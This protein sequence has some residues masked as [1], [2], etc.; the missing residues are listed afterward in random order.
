MNNLW[1]LIFV[2]HLVDLTALMLLIK[3]SCLLRLENVGVDGTLSQIFL[4]KDYKN[5]NVVGGQDCRNVVICVGYEPASNQLAFVYV[6]SHY[7]P[8][9]VSSLWFLYDI[10]SL[11]LISGHFLNS[12]SLSSFCIPVN[13]RYSVVFEVLI[14]I[15]IFR[16][17]FCPVSLLHCIITFC[18]MVANE[19]LEA[20][21]TWEIAWTR[22]EVVMVGIQEMIE[23]TDERADLEGHTVDPGHALDLVQEQG[24]LQECIHTWEHTQGQGQELYRGHVHY[25]HFRIHLHQMLHGHLKEVQ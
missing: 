1:Y 15:L 18:L 23:V 2:K 5:I 17:S 7:Y 16:I 3:M 21:Q 14:K 6:M 24:H 12:Q 13:S 20:D 8:L 9:A 4:K 19:D 25:R 22:S 11:F 10:L